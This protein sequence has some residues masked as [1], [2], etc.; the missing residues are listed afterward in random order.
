MP[1]GTWKWGREGGPTTRRYA[2]L[3]QPF[4]AR[5]NTRGCAEPIQLPGGNRMSTSKA[6]SRRQTLA[7]GGALGGM[8]ALTANGVNAQGQTKLT[9]WT[10]RLNTPELSAALK[11]ILAKFTEE[12]PGIVVNQE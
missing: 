9:F 8:F 7:L 10:V 11:G 4:A 1:L 12:N 6:L 2:S 5:G 3:K